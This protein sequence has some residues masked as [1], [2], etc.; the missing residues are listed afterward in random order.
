MRQRINDQSY[1]TFTV[2]EG[3][4]SIPGRGPFGEV[5]DMVQVS[6]QIADVFLLFSQDA[7]VVLCYSLENMNKWTSAVFKQLEGM[8]S[9][10]WGGET[11]SQLSL[12]ASNVLH[13]KLQV[14]SMQLRNNTV[15]FYL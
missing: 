12:H 1:Q 7:L 10:A 11:G 13:S 9:V 8:R 4:A 6:G 15:L 5:D 3:R 2:Q 14:Y